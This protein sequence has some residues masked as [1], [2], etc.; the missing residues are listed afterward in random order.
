M[1]CSGERL[2]LDIV[3]H[4]IA[5]DGTVLCAVVIARGKASIVLNELYPDALE[6]AQRHLRRGDGPVWICSPDCPG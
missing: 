1:V 2:P 3:I 6:H 4:S 5:G